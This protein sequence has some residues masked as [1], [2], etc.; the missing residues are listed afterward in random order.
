MTENTN[1][2]SGVALSRAVAEMMGWRVVPSDSLLGLYGIIRNPAGD[3][4]GTVKLG[5]DG[6][7]YAPTGS[8]WPDYADADD[9]FTLT[10]FG[11]L[12]RVEEW[13]ES[14]K[15]NSWIATY[16][17]NQLARGIG[18]WGSTPAE[19]ICRARL[20]LHEREGI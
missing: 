6:E 17:N 1:N 18:V 9:A 11:W 14:S 12:L 13:T 10:V 7:L 19:A 16:Y 3:D 2:L 15:P 4:V 8:M 5:N 20:A